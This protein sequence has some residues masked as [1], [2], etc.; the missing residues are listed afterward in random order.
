MMIIKDKNK[1]IS[2]MV[3][4]FMVVAWMEKGNSHHSFFTGNMRSRCR[5]TSG[6]LSNDSPTV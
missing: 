3:V 1:L 2:F 6:T 5:L 4:A